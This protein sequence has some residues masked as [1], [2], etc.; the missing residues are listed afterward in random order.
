METILQEIPSNYPRLETLKV[1]R[2]IRTSLPL[3]FL[4][5]LDRNRTNSTTCHGRGLTLAVTA[6]C[7]SS[8]H[9]SLHMH[10]RLYKLAL[11]DCAIPTTDHTQ[12]TTAIV[13][14]TTITHL[15]FI[16]RT[17]YTSGVEAVLQ[18]IPPNCPMLETLEID[19]NVSLLNSFPFLVH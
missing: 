19:S 13:S 7:H 11:Y 1:K 2:D 3:P 14:S 9:Y 16:D 18:E 15:L 8:I 10:C 6:L 12:L 17:I 5:L 4:S